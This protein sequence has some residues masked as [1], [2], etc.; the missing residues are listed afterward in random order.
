M[1]RAGAAAKRRRSGSLG[2]CGEGS[3]AWMR[4]A[5]KWHHNH[6]TGREKHPKGEMLNATFGHD[7]RDHSRNRVKEALLGLTT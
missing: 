2:V 5:F 4:R 3:V 7:L 1:A 6:K